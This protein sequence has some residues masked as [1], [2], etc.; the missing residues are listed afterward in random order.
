V[1]L[2]AGT[3][4]ELEAINVNPKKIVKGIPCFDDSEY[5]FSEISRENTQA[6]SNLAATIGWRKA[7]LGTGENFLKKYITDP[8]RSLFLSILS[9]KD[10]ENILDA[11]A[12]WGNISAQI[13][14]S[15]PSSSVYAADRT[16]ERMFFAEQIKKQERLENMHVLQCDIADPPFEKSFFDVVIMMGV[17]EWLG[18]SVGTL[19]PEAVQERGLKA[20]HD[21]MRPG[22]RLL[23]GI[24]NRI[25]YNYFLGDSDHSGMAFTSLMP[26]R[27]AD[28][29]VRS[30]RKKPYRTYT[31]SRRG[32]NQL[33][34]KAGF[35]SVKF[36]AVLPN[37]QFPSRICEIDLLKQVA[38]R[39]VTGSFPKFFLKLLPGRIMGAL[40][41][42]FYIVAER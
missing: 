32:Y 13:A 12:G 21:I 18:D 28:L 37:Y 4:F 7:A 39:R 35:S 5:F 26:R 30:R 9:I 1:H 42:S 27:V 38:Q 2:T 24:E 25:G 40:A 3:S 22:G 8:N 15:F 16:L 36:Y 17:L 33:L 10:G 14:K 23:I 41:P 11:G 19:P 29:Y 31:Y 34:T 6:L 20:V